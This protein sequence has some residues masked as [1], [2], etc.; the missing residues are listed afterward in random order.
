M[1]F[2]VDNSKATD[3]NF[4]LLEKGE[5]EVFITGTD[6]TI[7]SSQKGTLGAEVVVTVRDD[8]EQE[9]Q[10]KKVWHT[11]WVTPKTF[12]TMLQG[13]FKALGIDG[14]SFESLEEIQA[15]IAKE[16][17]G[18]A[19]RVFVDKE[20]YPKN[21]G[22]QGEKN[23]IKNWKVS[24]VGGRAKADDLQAPPPQANNIDDIPL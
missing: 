2:V 13:Y 9:G 10:K 3:V 12:E 16:S 20:T 11:H 5:Y 4:G 23:V 21:D 6:G 19:V 14:E 8:V 18:R 17:L 7:V 1:A 15:Y 22:T 24:E